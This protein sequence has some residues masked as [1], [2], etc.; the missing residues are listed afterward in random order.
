MEDIKKADLKKAQ[1]EAGTNAID[2]NKKV[3]LKTYIIKGD[4]VIG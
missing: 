3:W 4:N 1:I 2:R